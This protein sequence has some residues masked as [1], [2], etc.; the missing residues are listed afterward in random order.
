M[1]EQR[2]KDIESSI[3][4]KL[5]SN[6][7]GD[8]IEGKVGKYINENTSCEITAFAQPVEKIKPKGPPAGDIDVATDKYIIEVKKSTKAI[9]TKQIDKY[10]NSSNPDYFNYEGKQ[11]VFYID[12]PID[13]SNKYTAEMI[14]D[15]ENSGIKVVNSLEELK[16][17]I[18][19]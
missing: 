12:E 15:M 11:V 10:T 7:P 19:S 14:N 6:D 13:M 18:E 1:T 3:E 8:Q 4:T 2:P 17:V 9:K 5:T 16:G